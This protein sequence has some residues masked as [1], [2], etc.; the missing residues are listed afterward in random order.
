MKRVI[1]L[2]FLGLVLPGWT[3]AQR[4][5]LGPIDRFLFPPE[6]VMKNQEELQLTEEQRDSMVREIQQ[7][8]SEFTALHWDLQR[9][10]ENLTSLLKNVDL[11]E[12]PI[13][14][15]FDAV[16]DLERK[17]KRTQL[18]LMSPFCNQPIM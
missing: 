10:M 15:Q 14:E 6:L 11:E 13:L 1:W 17:V 16:L 7:A 8:Q 2:T 4:S 5:Q 3:M 12:G 9:E 18:I